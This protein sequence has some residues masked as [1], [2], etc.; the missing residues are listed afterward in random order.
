LSC[1]LL[2]SDFLATMALLNLCWSW[3]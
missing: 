2:A 1:V 3:D